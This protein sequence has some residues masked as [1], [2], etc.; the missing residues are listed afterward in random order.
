MTTWPGISPVQ[1]VR[2]PLLLMIVS[3]LNACGHN[4][5][6]DYAVETQSAVVELRQGPTQAELDAPTKIV[7]LGTGTPIPDPHRAGPSIA[8]IH[9][10]ESYV[11][12]V[13]AG[14]VH[15]ATVARYKYDIPSLYPTQIGHVFV[16]HMHSDHTL[17]LVEAAYTMWWRRPHGLAIYGPS[18][19][20]EM[21]DGMHRMMAPDTRI[22]MSGTQ[23]V[24]NPDGYRAN[25]TEIESGVVL[26]KDGIRI[27]AFAVNHGDV[28]PAFGYK[29]TTSDRSIVISGDTEVS[30]ELEKMATGVDI[31]MHEVISDTGL[32]RNSAGFQAY[33]KRSHTPASDLGRLARAAKP[34]LLVLYHGLYYGEPESRMVDE[35]KATYSGDVVLADDLDI[36]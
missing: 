27:E 22:R 7:I 28:K 11:F 34:K 19:I 25:V 9:R 12:D 1:L 10:G 26:E 18:G 3:G 5:T 15:N 8:V 21:V 36:F 4:L 14:S 31:L 6:T 20:A 17:D 30:P 33:H 23:P 32:A 35:V 13:G 29:I 2:V 16:T 24:Q